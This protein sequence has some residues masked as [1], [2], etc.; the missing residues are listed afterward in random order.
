MFKA[1]NIRCLQHVTC[2]QHVHSMFTT[3]SPHVHHMFTTCLPHVQQMFTTSSPYAHV[4]DIFTT[5]SWHVRNMFMTC[6]WHVHDVLMT[7]SQHVHNMLR[8]VRNMFMACSWHVHDMFM[9]CSWHVHDMFMTCSWHVH[10]MFMTCS[11]HVYIVYIFSIY[12]IWWQ[13]GI[14]ASYTST[15]RWSSLFLQRM[16]RMKK[17]RVDTLNSACMI[18]IM[19]I[20]IV[21]LSDIADTTED[22]ILIIYKRQFIGISILRT[23]NVTWERNSEGKKWRIQK[24]KNLKDVKM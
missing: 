18:Y 12:Y 9:T 22:N 16:K 23:P 21:C 3:C 19:K 4:H 15:G 14:I 10:D 2:S 17:F 20:E 7:C 24:L 1:C 6:S 5:C 11:W 13:I 8:H